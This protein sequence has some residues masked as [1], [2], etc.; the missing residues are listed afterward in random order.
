VLYS[1]AQHT[2]LHPTSLYS[3][4]LSR[5]GTVP[6]QTVKSS[7]ASLPFTLLH[8]ILPCPPRPVT[9]HTANWKHSKCK[10]KNL[11]VSTRELLEHFS[12]CFLPSPLLTLVSSF[13]SFCH[14]FLPPSFFFFPFSFLFP[15]FLPLFWRWSQ[16]E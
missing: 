3:T 8:P 4:V 16:E 6:L 12:L 1:T 13:N 9:R 2:T 14:F 15:I 7:H 5:A 11:Y 10:L